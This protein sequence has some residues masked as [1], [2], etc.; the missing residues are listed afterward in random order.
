MHMYLVRQYYEAMIRFEFEGCKLMKIHWR[1]LWKTAEQ[2]N[3][4]P[5]DEIAALKFIIHACQL[6]HRDLNEAPDGSLMD[7]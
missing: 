4:D 5:N 1:H 7:K 2:T 6:I 3:R